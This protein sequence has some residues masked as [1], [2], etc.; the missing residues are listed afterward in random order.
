MGETGWPCGN[1]GLCSLTSGTCGCYAGY[2]GPDCGECANGFVRVDEHCEPKTTFIPSFT[3]MWP[4]F[5]LLLLLLLLCCCCCGAIALIVKRKC[6]RREDATE[7]PHKFEPSITDATVAAE[8][9]LL[10][11]LH[12]LFL[13]LTVADISVFGADGRRYW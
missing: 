7:E 5:L 3:S 12:I 1:R 11:Y 2:M 13:M 9:R 6:K 10:S 8:V 4:W